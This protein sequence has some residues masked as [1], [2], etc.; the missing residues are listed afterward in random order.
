[1]RFKAR[2]DIHMPARTLILLM[3]FAFLA[4]PAL[5]AGP[6]RI[7]VILV[8]LHTSDKEETPSLRTVIVDAI[9]VDL[10]TR[11]AI[12]LTSDQAVDDAPGIL[13]LARSMKA[14][15]VIS[16][17]YSL[18]D[19]QVK[20]GL[21]WYDVELGKAYPEVRTEGS[22]DLSFDTVV[23]RLVADLLAGHE[24]RLASLP[25]LPSSAPPAA[26]Q[27]PAPEPVAPAAPPAPVETMPLARTQRVSPLSFSVGS[28]PFIP[29]FKASGYIQNVGLSF[30]VEGEYRFPLSGGL[31][32]IMAESGI[33]LFHAE[34][35]STANAYAIP[36]AAGVTYRTITGSFVDFA[37]QVNAGPSL[38]ILSP[39]S[40]GSSIGVVP[41]LSSG[42]GLTMN[43][44]APL[45]AS[46]HLDYVAI[47]VPDVIMGFVPSVAI[48]VRF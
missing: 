37:A 6:S 36:I 35:A 41:F 39:A 33:H 43:F 30:S 20:L 38:F 45:A 44:S 14:D 13:S 2:H 18:A 47:F 11:S 17:T 7:P 46:A 29:V 22:L 10:Q 23:S 32:G 9:T 27:T 15:F 40:G 25:L 4:S 28:A 24:E 3:L 21:T 12:A 1:L 19:R 31:L 8:L 34:R 48:D 5:Y 26:A 42:L 16:G